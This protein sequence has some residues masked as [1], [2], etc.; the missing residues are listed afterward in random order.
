MRILITGANG[1]IGRNLSKHLT[2]SGHCVI[3][4]VRHPVR[5]KQIQLDLNWAEIP[6]NYFKD[7]DVIVHCAA[8]VH[9]KNSI[10]NIQT[11]NSAFTELM[12]ERAIEDKVKRFFFISTVGV[13]GKVSSDTPISDDTA[14][15]PNNLYSL[16]KL[17]AEMAFIDK[18]NQ[19]NIFF[20]ILRLPLVIGE[21]APGTFGKLL[22][23]VD[24][25]FLFPF[26][27]V[28]NKRSIIFIDDLSNCLVQMIK[29]DL[30]I[31]KAGIICNPL[32]LS[33][34][35]LI[36]HGGKLLS[37]KVRLFKFPKFLFWLLLKIF[38]QEKI[39]NQ[40]FDSLVCI[41]HPEFKKI[42]NLQLL[43]D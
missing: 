40:L 30:Y 31:N 25:G 8:N 42:L 16:S 23:A 6:K 17:Q 32:P 19:N 9:N 5:S 12:L 43:V 29:D 28:T 20:N 4:S 24:K 34:E 2:A 26:K 41:P 15:D 22:H 39:Y 21:N 13:F 3:E 38:R 11:H 33:T 27:G 36:L 7:I 35:D 37:K 10:E 1:F 14:L 18:F